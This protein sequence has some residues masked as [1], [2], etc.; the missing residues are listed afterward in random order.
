MLGA[1]LVCLPLLYFV[2][3]VLAHGWVPQGD[4]ALVAVRIHDV[5]SVHPPLVGMRST[6]SVSSP[7]VYAHHPGPLEF[8]LLAIPYTLTGF[9]PWSIIVGDAI[10]ASFFAALAVW[11]AYRAIGLNG[12]WIAAALVLLTERSFGHVLVQPLNTWPAVLALLA[13]LVLA[14]RLVLGQYK[15]LPWYVGCATYAAQAQVIDFAVVAVLSA[16][17]AALGLLRWW[18]RR[19]TVWPIPGAVTSGMS[20]WRR[21][22]VVSVGLLIVLWLPPMV[23]V[24]VDH[25]SNLSELVATFSG[26]H[27]GPMVGLWTSAKDVAALLVPFGARLGPLGAATPDVAGALGALLVIAVLI[28]TV[29]TGRGVFRQGRGRDGAVASAAAVALVAAGAL[30][31]TGSHAVYPLQLLY[32]NLVQPAALF[33]SL[34]AVWAVCRRVV[35]QL[36]SSGRLRPWRGASGAITAS[37]A[38]LALA[39]IP[40]LPAVHNVTQQSQG[41]QRLAGR[42]VAAAADLLGTHGG[43]HRPVVVRGYGTTSYGSLAPAVSSALIAD[44][45]TV[46]FDSVWPLRQDDEFRRSH[47]AP[48]Y[49]HRLI[50]RERTGTGP[51]SLTTV[52]G[53][54]VA[55]TVV[56]PRTGD[57]QITVELL[58]L[59]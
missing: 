58:L 48:T 27:S 24:L 47:E 13:A 20:Q 54:T 5:W 16:F 14:W 1:A 3:T 51:W 22:G 40:V 53:R 4:E 33:A 46:Y 9:A 52:P 11:H 31:W 15:A 18:D 38:A 8:Y 49:S 12:A 45:R 7:G 59:A 30:V 43:L 2:V 36:V 34:V 26:S 35:R 57:P 10:V 39:A 25:P 6:S 56:V 28:H 41:D 32:L 21:P 42:V 23:D 19:G 37:L 55:T 50:I 17:L 44:G 29:W